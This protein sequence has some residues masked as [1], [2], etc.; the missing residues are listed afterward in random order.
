MGWEISI[1]GID[2]LA[3]LIVLAVL[4]SARGG[5]TY[6]LGNPAGIS[7]LNLAYLVRTSLTFKI[8][9]KF[10]LGKEGRGAL[11]DHDDYDKTLK[12]LK[13]ELIE[14]I[15]IYIK[16][17]CKLLT[18]VSSPTP[19]VVIESPAPIVVPHTR[20]TRRASARIYKSCVAHS[21]H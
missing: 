7:L 10:V 18:P 4:A 20:A 5:E 16:K 12:S 8:E 17:F 21:P 6:H 3:N 1:L 13:Y 19:R 14:N 11:V 15:D 9:L 2:D